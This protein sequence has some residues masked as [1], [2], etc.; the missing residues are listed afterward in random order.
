V[1][2]RK[3]SDADLIGLTRTVDEW[4]LICVTKDSS[5]KSAPKLENHM[6]DKVELCVALV[7]IA[8][9]NDAGLPF[10]RTCYICEG[11]NPLVFY[12]IV[13]DPERC[14]F[15]QLKRA[16]EMKRLKNNGICFGAVSRCG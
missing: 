3:S 1:G 16:S 9:M 8:D 2:A 11:D 12:R 5:K 6:K 7:E 13:R 10:C 14:G 4:V 15:D